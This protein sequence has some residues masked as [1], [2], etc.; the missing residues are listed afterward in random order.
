MAEGRVAWSADFGNLALRVALGLVF[1]PHGVQKLRNPAAFAGFL[2][3]LH[4]P[5]PMAVAWLVA[6]LETAGAGMLILGFLTRF[7]ALGL[8]VDML[9]AILSVKIGMAHAP[10]TSG[11][12]GP[13]WE[14]EFLLGAA[15]LALV[16]TGPG[17]VAVDQ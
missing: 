3:P 8:A 2:H 6:L 16:F 10:F 1:I 17:S 15:A 11:R 4:V 9:V 14:F 13:D 5:A 12:Q 7:V